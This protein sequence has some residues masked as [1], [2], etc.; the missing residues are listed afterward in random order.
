[1]LLLLALFLCCTSVANATPFYVEGIN[2]EDPYNYGTYGG[3]YLFSF[4]YIP[5]YTYDLI[6]VDF[7]GK[8]TGNFIVGVW[9]DNSGRPGSPLN[10]VD[11]DLTGVLGYQGV[12]FGSPTPLEAG[13]TYW[14]SFYADNTLETY[15]NGDTVKFFVNTWGPYSAPSLGIKFFSPVPIPEPATMILLASG[16]F[17]LVAFSRRRKFKKS[18]SG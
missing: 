17:G 1:M 5:N 9:D 14:V 12:P 16:L 7:Y 2:D 18:V 15:T 6:E 4:E 10:E 13:N 3:G 8:G 11:F